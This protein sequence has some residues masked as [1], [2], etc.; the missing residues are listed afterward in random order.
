MAKISVDADHAT[1]S[2]DVKIDK[3]DIWQHEEDENGDPGI[4]ICF[5]E[6]G[7]GAAVSIELPYNELYRLTVPLFKELLQGQRF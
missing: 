4:S 6:S 3:V 2:T 7:A 5:A 1:F